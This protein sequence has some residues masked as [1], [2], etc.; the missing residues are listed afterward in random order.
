[1]NIFREVKLR[2][3]NRT[4]SREVQ[5]ILIS[6]HGCWWI[7]RRE[8]QQPRFEDAKYL[9]IDECGKITWGHRE[10]HFEDQEYVELLVRIR[11][12]NYLITETAKPKKL[13]IEEGTYTK[14]QLLEM[15]EKLED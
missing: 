12:K 7:D 15:A 1:M 9:F 3:K 13:K 2:I 4:E 6:D 8:P 5:K 11:T 10:E 14:R